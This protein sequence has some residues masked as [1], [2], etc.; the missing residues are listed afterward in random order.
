VRG[1]NGSLQRRDAPLGGCPPTIAILFP[2]NG[3]E[4]AQ[5]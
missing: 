2:L 1:K 3:F 4:I 5:Y